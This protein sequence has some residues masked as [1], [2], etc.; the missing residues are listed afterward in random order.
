MLKIIPSGAKTNFISLPF[1]LLIYKRAVK[2]GIQGELI[3]S[4]HFIDLQCL[5]LSLEIDSLNQYI[6]ELTQMN[7]NRRGI[8]E[9]RQATEEDFENL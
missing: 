3:R 7:L 5:I 9:V 1:S 6:R 2:V 8:K 4:L